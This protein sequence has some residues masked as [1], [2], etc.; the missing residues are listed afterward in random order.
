MEMSRS[1][2]SV[3]S[4]RFAD[5][6]DYQRPLK[7]GIL[8]IATNNERAILRAAQSTGKTVIATMV[9][10]GILATITSDLR[11]SYDE[12][13]ELA[14]EFGVKFQELPV[15][16]EDCIIFSTDEFEDTKAYKAYDELGWPIGLIHDERDPE[17][18]HQ[19]GGCP[20]QQ[21]KK[22]LDTDAL[23]IL[24]GNN[25]QLYNPDYVNGRVIIID[26]DAF[27]DFRNEYEN[28]LDKIN[29]FLAARDEFDIDEIPFQ[30]TNDVRKHVIDTLDDIGIS[31]Y[32]YRDSVG[33]FHSKA[34]LLTYAYFQEPR[35]TAGQYVVD[36][37]GNRTATYRNL[38]NGERT[39]A[40]GFGDPFAGSIVM[41]EP[42]NLSNAQ[43][44]I[45]L[46][47]TPC[48]PEWELLLGSD[49]KKYRLFD[50][51]GMNEY[52]R[53]NG[54]KFK[55]L[56]NHIA[57]SQG[58][59][60]SVWKIASYLFELWMEHG[61]K[62]DLI[63][64]KAM[65]NQ[66]EEAGLDYLYKDRDVDL[67]FGHVHGKN[68][69][70][71]SSL[72]LVAGSPSRSDWYFK[73]QAA[74][75]GESA[76]PATDD[77]GNR[78][79]GYDLDY[80]NDLAN[81]LLYSSRRHETFQA[82]TRIARDDDVDG[83]AY[84]ATGM[85]VDEL[86]VEKVGRDIGNGKFDACHNVRSE[87]DLKVLQSL[88]ENDGVSTSDIASQFDFTNRTVR[89]IL[90]R[91]RDDGVVKTTGAGPSTTHHL[92]DSATRTNPLCKSIKGE[93]P[94]S[95]DPIPSFN[96]FGDV[97]L[98]PLNPKS[99]SRT[100]NRVERKDPRDSFNPRSWDDYTDW[101]IE[102]MKKAEKRKLF[103]QQRL[104][105]ESNE[106]WDDVLDPIELPDPEDTSCSDEHTP[107]L[108][109]ET[110]DSNP[111]C[112]EGQ[113]GF[114]GPEVTQEEIEHYERGPE[115]RQSASEGDIPPEVRARRAT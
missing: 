9:S 60:L 67:H 54:L 74:L 109:G 91:L 51:E 34:P 35:E 31:P 56:N 14:K 50:D 78:L 59:D 48:D 73:Y 69:L 18:Q 96:P 41:F 97:D 12:T 85:V 68:D 10:H 101:E 32:F 25:V 98:S 100:R 66:L 76:V 19:E 46:D 37:P 23:G 83:T 2:Y 17:C 6:V 84:F 102:V 111:G 61:E 108:E 26:E 11:D 33:Q 89:R 72:L 87:N 77:D 90:N 27:E 13:E 88:M 24:N 20:Y 7:T 63:T 107:D 99:E 81:E 16:T 42:P 103:E 47:A 5:S 8:H 94:D 49:V 64:S 40:N 43:A 71:K 62:P 93:C 45:A 79:N 95:D 15:G 105:L 53:S 106:K 44:V 38:N 70:R 110:P 28:P 80:Q 57:A 21:K 36:L 1:D 55:M 114:D 113:T 75:F 4:E 39:D 86:D 104:A 58:G 30:L 115:Y 82:A 22:A 112:S 92:T 65:F 29:R 52:F 3:L